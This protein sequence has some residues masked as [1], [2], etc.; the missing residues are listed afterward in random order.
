MC[1]ISCCVSLDPA[2][3]LEHVVS[4]MSRLVS[5]RGPDNI[6]TSVLD[7]V[8]LGHSRL[9]IVDLSASSNQPF[10]DETNSF[11]VIFNGE[12]Y[13]YQFL[14]S[15]LEQNNFSFRTYSDTEVLLNSYIHWGD[16]CVDHFNGMWS[17]VIFD[18][19]R[20]KIF[21]SRDRFG[22]KPFYYVYS[23][24]SLFLS[25]EIRQ[26]LPFIDSISANSEVLEDYLVGISS[27]P[28]DNTFFDSI[29]KLNP[30]HNMVIDAKTLDKHIYPYYKFP[31]YQ[32]NS[33][34]HNASLDDILTEFTQ[35]LDSSITSR[36]PLDVPVAISLS[37]GLDSSSIAYFLST[38]PKFRDGG[39]AFSAVS[40]EVRG[41][42]SKYAEFVSNQLG[43]DLIKIKPDYNNFYQTLSSVVDAQEEPFG[44][45]SIIMQYLIMESVSKTGFKVVINGQGADELLFGYE[46]YVPAYI[47]SQF[48]H[49]KYL[50][51]I[52][53]AYNFNLNNHEFSFMNLAKY[54]LYFGSPR[55]RQLIFANRS[56]VL[57]KRNPRIRSLVRDYWS[58]SRNLA[59]LR[60]HEMTLS[61]L[62]P[63]LRF[64]DKNSMHHS[65]ESRL[66]FLDHELV[67]FCSSIPLDLFFNGGWTKSILRNAMSG[68]LPDL[69]TRRKDKIGY[70]APQ[71]SWLSRHAPLAFNLVIT[72]NLLSELLSKQYT[73]NEFA[74]LDHRLQWRL[75]SVAMWENQ[76]NVANL[77]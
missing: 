31:S 65:V 24:K 17:F 69:I 73:L 2:I 26:L 63:L 14:R 50:S 41:D 74:N 35:R 15:V 27:D 67:E 34:F 57:S 9:S 28:I 10:V 22:E 29:F 49:S 42:E 66:P 77:R 21:C 16:K 1:G 55:V 46:R 51:G 38:Q 12:I 40:S 19:R 33:F 59:Q 13:N 32:P 72:S 53:S 70:E 62:P 61:N 20:H 54:L 3:D 47:I 60:Q 7:N 56:K 76:F 58:K 52:S 30:G 68:K 36:I 5:H 4:Q 18:R 8:A 25:S 23:R 44:S 75:L 48:K 64:D 39:V 71:R 43:I 11:T 37:G 45:A 6:S